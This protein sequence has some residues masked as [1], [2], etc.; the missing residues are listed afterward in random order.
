[1]WLTGWG[2]DT[3]KLNHHHD[4][5]AQIYAFDFVMINNNKNTFKNDGKNNEDYFCFESQILAAAKGEV[6]QVVEG[7][8][9]NEPRY[10]NGYWVAGNTV[11][12]KHSKK[13]FSFLAHFKQN[14]I[15][16]KVG[17]KV[18]TG[19]LLGL[20]GNSGR[21][22]EPHLHFHL[23]DRA[24]TLFAKGVKCFFSQI[25]LRK[26]NNNQTIKN[27]SPIKG[28]VIENLK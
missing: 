9:D 19:D 26:D 6:V 20:C 23:Q 13:L 5:L 21:S 24:N 15:K 28:D 7:V 27:Y 16:V 22:S 10:L 25:N 14:S 11:I 18:K 4:N 12:I 3:K 8:D 1:M 2:G 17:D